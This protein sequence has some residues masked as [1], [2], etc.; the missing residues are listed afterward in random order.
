MTLGDTFNFTGSTLYEKRLTQLDVRFTKILRVGGSRIRA[1]FDIFNIFNH[2]SAT[3]LVANYTAPGL[4][5]PR[6]AQVMGGRLF[7]FGGH[8]VP[9]RHGGGTDLRADDL[10]PASDGLGRIGHL[11]IAQALSQ[12]RAFGHC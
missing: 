12:I 1:W 4:P 9:Q 7:K 10:E 5:Y 11:G 2:V 8:D 6:V 3:N